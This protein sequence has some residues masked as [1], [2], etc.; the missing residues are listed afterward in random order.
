MKVV[1]FDDIIFLNKLLEE[2][3][4]K[5]SLKDSC[6]KQCIEI[7]NLENL[8]NESLEIIEKYLKENNFDFFY[9]D[10]KKYIF[11]NK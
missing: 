2:Y 10:N 9:S 6:I 3:E 5:L 7:K 1:R 4:I 11:F 8:N